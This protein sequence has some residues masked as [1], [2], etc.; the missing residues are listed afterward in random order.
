MYY[1]FIT[2]FDVDLMSNIEELSGFDP[3][4]LIPTWENPLIVDIKINNKTTIFFIT[5]FFIINSYKKDNSNGYTTV[6]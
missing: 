6:N 2:P 4:E 1:R 3:S 5:I